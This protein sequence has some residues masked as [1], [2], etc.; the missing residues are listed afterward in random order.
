[1]LTNNRSGQIQSGGKGDP[2]IAKQLSAQIDHFLILCIYEQ[3]QSQDGRN[4]ELDQLTGSPADIPIFQELGGSNSFVIWDHVYQES[5]PVFNSL[6]LVARKRLI[7][8]IAENIVT[9]L[10]IKNKKFSPALS[11]ILNDKHLKKQ[12]IQNI[13]DIL[14]RDTFL[15]DNHVWEHFCSWFRIHL[16]E[17]VLEDMAQSLGPSRIAQL[18]KKELNDL[19][20]EHISKNL[21]KNHD[22]IQKFADIV[23]KYTLDWV[24]K[25][26]EY[27]NLENSSIQQIESLLTCK[28]G[29]FPHDFPSANIKNELTFHT[30]AQS[31]I[32]VLNNALYQSVRE[33]FYKLKFSKTDESL[34]PTVSLVK[35]NMEGLLQIKPFKKD[36]YSFKKHHTIVKETWEDVKALSDLGADILD[37]LCT[38]FISNAKHSE[39]IVEIQL[40][41]LLAIRGLKPKL[42]GDGRRGGYEE[43]QRNQVLQSLSII[44]KLWIS[45]DKAVFYENGR[46]AE[47][48]LEGRAFIFVDEDRKECPVTNEISDKMI[49]YKVDKV[50]AKLLVGSGRQVALLPL[51]VLHYDPYRKTWEKR[52]ARYLSWRWRIQA[53]KG[54]F[55]QPNKVSTLLEALGAEMNERTPSRT[56]E[57]LEKALDTLQEDGVIESWYYEKWEESIADQKGWGRIWLQSMIIISPPE[58]IKEHYRPIKKNLQGKNNVQFQNQAAKE[59]DESIGVQVR[60]VRDR[61]QLSLTQVAEELGISPSY[62]SHIERGIK[63]P[64]KKILYK[65]QKWLHYFQ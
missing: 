45:L 12:S 25:V 13:N 31:C 29:L 9:Y 49:R 11:S 17:W 47:T 3:D 37:A 10:L 1:M 23:N 48:K 50:F 4:I 65:V 42:G 30:A 40:D 21:T 55:L 19:F 15:M 41:D 6:R 44:Q 38:F 59:T 32:Y 43:K 63:V 53:R 61:H 33:A 5:A 58:S 57:R 36:H 2:H 16:T 26:I 35:G 22:F 24:K 54:Q 46:R 18:D 28:E 27:F 52:L 7:W 8:Q 39:D 56:R 20:Y 60:E 34:W 51:K 64:S 14:Q 62:L